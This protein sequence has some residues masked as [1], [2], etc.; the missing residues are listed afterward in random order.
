[1]KGLRQP[2]NRA[3]GR[4]ATEELGEHTLFIKP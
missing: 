2:I 1:M 3:L 4:K